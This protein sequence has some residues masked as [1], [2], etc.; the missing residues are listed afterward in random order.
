MSSPDNEL[1]E[2]RKKFQEEITG[3]QNLR[4]TITSALERLRL[5]SDTLQRDQAALRTR[6]ER[7]V[8]SFERLKEKEATYKEKGNNLF[9]AFIFYSI[10][11]D[12]LVFFLPQQFKL[13]SMKVSAPS[14]PPITNARALRS[15]ETWRSSNNIMVWRTNVK[16]TTDE[17]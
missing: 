3:V 6:E 7:V 5:E 14:S 15:A 12:G 9:H 11:A 8:A 17:R 1:E 16:T 2:A 10:F 4:L 13:S